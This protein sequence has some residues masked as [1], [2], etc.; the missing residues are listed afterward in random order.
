MKKTHFLV[1][2]LAGLFYFSN[3]QDCEVTISGSTLVCS[4]EET[5]TLTASP[6]FESYYWNTGEVGMSIEV[7]K[8]VY[9]L[10]AVREDGCLA[11]DRFEVKQPSEGNGFR[12]G[13][14]FEGDFMLDAYYYYYVNEPDAYSFV[15]IF[16]GD[17]V[18]Y[19]NVIEIDTVGA[20]TDTFDLIVLY[21][22]YCTESIGVDTFKIKQFDEDY[23]YQNFDS[24]YICSNVPEVYDCVRPV[25]KT[26]TYHSFFISDFGVHV[27]CTRYFQFL[28]DPCISYDTAYWCSRP[29][30]YSGQQID[31]PGFYEVAEPLYLS[32]TVSLIHLE[33]IQDTSFTYS[34][35]TLEF[36]GDGPYEYNGY[37]YNSN[38]FLYTRYYN[39]GGA[40]DSMVLERV[41]PTTTLPYLEIDT[42]VCANETFL[43]QGE[44]YEP[45]EVY[46]LNYPLA[47]D[48]DSTVYLKVESL[49]LP[50]L[51][52]EFTLCEGDTLMIDGNQYLEAGNY[53]YHKEASIGCD[54]I[55]NLSIIENLPINVFDEFILPDNGNSSGA[56]F[57]NLS[58]GA[59]PYQLNWS[60]GSNLQNILGLDAGVYELEVTDDNGCRSV[61][62][63]EVPLMLSTESAQESSDI[64]IFP[65]PTTGILNIRWQGESKTQLSIYALD[66][67]LVWAGQTSNNTQQIDISA[68]PA[69]MY[70][71][72]ARNNSG[73]WQQ[74]VIRQ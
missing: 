21:E 71:I 43:W 4:S 22:N 32:D 54:T 57:I 13:V 15:W 11:Y 67:T 68:M 62:T 40:C 72:Q 42:V 30:S 41:I 28:Q 55:V 26:G 7:G 61:F 39:T 17:T 56:I 58:G 29:F 23:Y 20:I 50:T 6:G 45:G 69:G 52:E 64:Q 1:L 51:S 31:G 12:G 33:V 48:C 9:W 66:G 10:Y 8:G 60:N 38:P 34:I 14:R 2:L 37:T 5:T 70:F 74:K 53:S 49:T 35:N 63:F 16:D 65:N 25:T 59:P 44:I 47:F 3:A 36:C 18:S 24:V 73:L 27:M 46:E 19:E